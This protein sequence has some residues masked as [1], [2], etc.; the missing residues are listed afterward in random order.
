MAALANPLQAIP[1][2]SKSGP[3]IFLAY[4]LS[5]MVIDFLH[6]NPAALVSCALVCS[7]WSPAAQFHLFRDVRLS[8]AL[9]R[10]RACRTLPTSEL[11]HQAISRCAKFCA[12]LRSSPRLIPLVRT[13]TVDA[14][15]EVRAELITVPFT[16]LHTLALFYSQK[17]VKHDAQFDRGLLFL[18]HL[19]ALLALPSLT[20][21][22]FPA[23]KNFLT[24]A[25]LY[26]C[27]NLKT[28]VL[29]NADIV[30][31]PLAGVVHPAGTC[32][33]RIESLTMWS[34]LIRQGGW[35]F[36][37]ST[38]V[39]EFSRLRHLDL[40]TVP[41][42]G[43]WE[44]VRSF[45]QTIEHLAFDLLSSGV[46]LALLPKLHHLECNPPLYD[47]IFDLPRILDVLRTLGPDN[48]VQTIVFWVTPLAAVLVPLDFG[49]Q[50]TALRLPH[51]R[52]A[53]VRIL[54]MGSD[55]IDAALVTEVVFP[56]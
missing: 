47:G 43:D 35:L 23:D 44:F 27:K 39:F 21:V 19:V 31:M 24:S 7:E 30:Q 36:P 29:E 17:Y 16:H 10:Y 11:T 32:R 46:N 13:L 28:L 45:S 34:S 48:C 12:A 52:R 6:A 3:S 33:P 14:C 54:Q 40:W 50:M 5:D 20:R 56:S 37:A 8:P 18:H 1:I 26:P 15:C 55:K 38:A 25:V 22:E 53:A 2:P 4:E 51:L 49:A 41:F 9:D 42:Y